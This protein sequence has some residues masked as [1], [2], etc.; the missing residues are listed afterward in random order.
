MS[1][2]KS[3]DGLQRRSVKK[4]VTATKSVT[5]QRRKIAK[6]ATNIT[7]GNIQSVR[8][9]KTTRKATESRIGGLRKGNGSLG[10]DDYEKSLQAAETN[11]IERLEELSN[12]VDTDERAAIKSFLK[13][14]QDSEATDLAAIPLK[15]RKKRKMKN[16]DDK[17]KKKRRILKWFLLILLVALV[18]GGI[19]AYHNLNDLVADI[20]NG[21]NIFTA[22][23]SDPTTPLET[24][25]LG[26]TNILVFGTEGY[27]MN[28][29]NYAGGFLTD[30][31]MLV[32]IDQNTGDAKAVSLPRDL[33]ASTCTATGKLNE[34]F[35]CQYTKNDG[36]E[37]SIK[38]YEEEGA[39]ALEKEFE[40]VLGVEIQYHA[41]ANWGALVQIVDA[42]GGIDVVFTYG[43]Q[44]WD[45]DEVTIETTDKRGL[46]DGPSRNKFFFQYPNGEVV[47]L[48][49]EKAL[50]VARTRN[51]Y[52]GYGAARGNFSREYFQQRI[53]EAIVKKIKNTKSF[54]N[55]GSILA[56]KSA[57]GDNLRTNFK[58][59]EIK[60]LLKLAK[61]LDFASLQ[62]IPL[63]GDEEN[64]AVMTTGMI[65]NIS[66]VLPV[67]GVGQYSQIHN[68]IKKKLYTGGFFSE[69]AEITV[70]NATSKSGLASTE[71]T[72]LID[73]GFNALNAANAPS[74]YEAFDGVQIFAAADDKNATKAELEKVYKT[75]ASSEIP[76][77]LT[78]YNSDFIIVLGGG[79]S[80]DTE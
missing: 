44:T 38:K 31:M 22:I 14:R 18:G 35:Y 13:E 64:A 43:D 39:A 29:P 73:H 67:A 5:M 7:R 61:D 54:L 2:A 6:Q 36:S 41:H 8:H 10:L 20:T 34:A 17:P 70:L 32:S 62:T 33:K 60:T 75:S 37:E 58:D 78:N 9:P 45:G 47:H 56:L 50:G 16:K 15:E 4:Q 23:L 40:K 55:L 53:I 66:Y 51:A 79:F 52:G 48:D 12:D 24:D 19:Y 42:I 21:G 63:Y 77:S 11:Q 25:S 57:V 69:N 76:E 80:H 30:T 27:D 68:Y 71:K 26:R 72:W 49:G 59:T 3:I 65:N 28:N 74:D 46:A 1:G